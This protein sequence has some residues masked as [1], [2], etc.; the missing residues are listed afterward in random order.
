MQLKLVLI[1][2]TLLILILS[3]CTPSQEGT[4]V[5]AT[6]AETG[7]MITDSAEFVPVDSVMSIITW[8]G[9]KPTGKHNGVIHIKNGQIALQEDTLAG[10]EIS[11]D[12]KSIQV[13]DIKP[14]EEANK[15]LTDHLLSED[16]FDA[17]T[18]PEGSFEVTR[19]ESYDSTKLEVKDEFITENT[20]ALIKEFMVENPT[21]L[22]SGNLTLRG[23][24]KNITFPAVVKIGSSVVKIE[25]KFNIDRTDW[26]LSYNSE[27][28]AIDKAKDKFIYNTVNV[29]F[30]LEAT[31][32]Q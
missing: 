13:M 17:V 18:Y 7:L 15:K 4:S 16:F 8:I 9:S 19:L 12:I 25:A 29:G 5:N 1:S 28:R 6:K 21:H 14:E 10:G 26:N 20:P 32:Q 30:S 22:I 3:S 27:S 31:R 24:T 23:V 2:T 11:I